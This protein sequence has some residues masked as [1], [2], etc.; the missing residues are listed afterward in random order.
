M[1]RNVTRDD[2]AVTRPLFPRRPVVVM[3]AFCLVVVALYTAMAV[4]ED[5]TVRLA[6][7]CVVL[8]GLLLW[9]AAIRAT[10]TK[11]RAPVEP[12][13]DGVVVVESPAVLVGLLLGAWLAMLCAVAA[14]LVVAATDFDAIESPGGLLVMVVGGLASLPDLLR[15]LRGRLHRWRVVA[16]GHGLRYR[17]YHTDMDLAWSE[18][19]GIHVP[20]KPPGVAVRRQD[21]SPA[22][23]LPASAFDVHPVALAEALKRRRGLARR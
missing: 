7:R 1:R 4:L 9:G 2:A 16:D 5:G 3:H 22:L 18:I 21:G 20:D 17:G 13:S 15:L 8:S 23:V 19:S 10:R 11:R 14:F 12:R 6:A